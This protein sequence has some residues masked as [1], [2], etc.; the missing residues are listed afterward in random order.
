MKRY[1]KLLSVLSIVAFVG[2]ACGGGGGSA[3]TSTPASSSGAMQPG[4]TLR[5]GT[6]ADISGGWDPAKEYEAIAWELRARRAASCTPTWRRPRPRCPR[7][8]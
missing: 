5:V 7:T 3:Q 2:V 8:S 1:L 6:P 4:G